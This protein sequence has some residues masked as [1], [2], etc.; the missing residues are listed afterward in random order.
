MAGPWVE[1]VSLVKLKPNHPSRGGL[2]QVGCG[3]TDLDESGLDK[4]AL[5]HTV[6]VEADPGRLISTA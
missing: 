4:P 2:F 5:K 3:Q 6:D 1:K